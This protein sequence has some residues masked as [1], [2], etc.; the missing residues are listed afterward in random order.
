MKSLILRIVSRNDIITNSST[1]ILSIKTTKTPEVLKELILNYTLANDEYA[2][3]YGIVPNEDVRIT[4]IN[5]IPELT[6][7]FGELMLEEKSKFMEIMCKRHGLDPSIPGEL[8]MIDIDHHLD[9]T[10]DF[11]RETLGAV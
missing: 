6:E 1:E 9:E 8:Y 11:L 7:L 10:I 5:P 3:E 2:K 4:E